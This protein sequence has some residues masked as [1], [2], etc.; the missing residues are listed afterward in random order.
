M[1]RNTFYKMSAEDLEPFATNL[2]DVVAGEKYEI[3]A[4]ILASLNT[5]VT[6][7]NAAV[8]E[9]EAAKAAF[10]AANN[11][12]G[13]SRQSLVDNISAVAALVYSNSNLTEAE[14]TAT[15]LAVH[16]ASRSTVVPVE[17][18]NLVA[19]AYSN[20][21]AL[22]KF[23]RGANPYG[24]TFEVES[25]TNGT[26]WS[27]WT[28]SQKQRVTLSGVAPGV[29]RWFRVRAKKGALSSAWTAPV[30]VYGPEESLELQIAA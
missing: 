13:A 7:L 4:P 24:V 5:A 8:D 28:T 22:L 1:P 9:A 29:T 20:G 14:I 11:A 12:K 16:D 2:A 6:E 27:L 15:G 3:P 26:N 30:A 25:S 17:V 21:Q 10:H 23:H 18:T 19:E